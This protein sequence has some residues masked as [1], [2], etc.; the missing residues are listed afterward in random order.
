MAGAQ[1]KN[2]TASPTSRGDCARG[3]AWY[4]AATCATESPHC[5]ASSRIIGVSTV[6]GQTALAVTPVG[7]SSWA[8]A[9]VK[10]TIANFEAE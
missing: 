7:A 6:P 9:W 10:P 2:T 4:R 5:V 1:A 8:I 3:W